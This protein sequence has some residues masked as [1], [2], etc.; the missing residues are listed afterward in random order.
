MST[1]KNP[2]AISKKIATQSP[3]FSGRGL[4][5]GGLATVGLVTV[6]AFG[7][8]WFQYGAAREQT[9]NATLHTHLHSVSSRVS[10]TVQAVLV[11]DNQTVEARQ[12][13]VRLDPR[14]ATVR[15]EQARAALSAAR[16]KLEEAS[17]NIALSERKAGAQITE[18]SGSGWGAEVEVNTAHST[19]LE[20]EANLA[21]VRAQR[22]QAQANCVVAEANYRRF[23]ALIAEKAISQQQFDSTKASYQVALA[24]RQAAEQVV[25]QAQE[26]LKQA[27]QGVTSAD[28]RV[29]QSKGALQSAQ[30]ATWQTALNR[31]QYETARAAVEQAEAELHQAELQL[32]YTTI[33]APVQGR[34]GHKSVEIGQQTQPGQALLW[35]TQNNPWV[36]A[37]FKETQLQQIREG[38]A[39]EV[40][41]DTFPEHLFTGTVESISPASGAQFALLPP[42]NATGNFTKIV[43]RVPVKIVLSQESTKGYENVLVPGMS[44]VVRVKVR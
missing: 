1:T 25:L 8:Q 33:V 4:L 9:D 31:A 21:A 27:E 17:V 2:P 29:L 26:K 35:V 34:I 44:A 43:Q 5:L 18:A 23:E 37:N 41:I 28:A 24:T 19:V 14:D 11:K 6:T 36:V 12:V 30:A 16:S 38:Q 13:L 15:L 42:D 20:A 39:A 10:G 40:H 7:W 22:A 3:K 32:S